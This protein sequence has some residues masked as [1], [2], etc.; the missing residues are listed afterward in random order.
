MEVG[1]PCLPHPHPHPSERN[2]GPMHV[3]L[4]LRPRPHRLQHL[5]QLR[6]A[7]PLGRVHHRASDVVTLAV[8]AGSALTGPRP[9]WAPPKLWATLLLARARGVGPYCALCCVLPRQPTRRPP[10][11]GRRRASGTSFAR[12]ESQLARC[13]P[14]PFHSCTSAARTSSFTQLFLPAPSPPRPA[15]RGDECTGARGHPLPRRAP[16][17]P[18]TRAAFLTSSSRPAPRESDAQ[19]LVAP[20]PAANPATPLS[21]PTAARAAAGTGP[22]ASYPT[23]GWARS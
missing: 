12:R 3:G 20:N 2:P 6:R 9:N 17:P 7:H 10:A 19:Q 15:Y 18:R 1:G 11:A 5:R 14:V 13:L 4:W 8:G 22:S 21:N 23:A 16:E